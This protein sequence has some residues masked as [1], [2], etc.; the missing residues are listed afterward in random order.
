MDP[1]DSS[2]S[3]DWLRPAAGPGSSSSGGCQLR[4]QKTSESPGMVSQT[5]VPWAPLPAACAQG[6]GSQTQ[7][8]RPSSLTFHHEDR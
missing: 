5:P 2:P 3:P 6:L 4:E 1:R 8:C 7:A